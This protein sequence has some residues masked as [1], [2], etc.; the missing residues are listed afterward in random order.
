MEDHL[1]ILNEINREISYITEQDSYI[2]YLSAE[3]LIKLHDKITYLLGELNSQALSLQENPNLSEVQKAQI[4]ADIKKTDVSASRA[5][6]I[7]SWWMDNQPRKNARDQTKEQVQPPDAQASPKVNVPNKTSFDAQASK[8]QALPSTSKDNNPPIEPTIEQ[9]EVLMNPEMRAIIQQLRAEYLKLAAQNNA[10]KWNGSE[11]E[12]MLGEKLEPNLSHAREENE[13]FKMAMDGDDP[14]PNKEGNK[15][16]LQLKFDKVQLNTFSG[17]LTE[18]IAFRDQYLE[19]V[20]LNGNLPEMSK[21]LQLR[22]LLKGI[23][24]DAISSFSVSAADYQAAWSTLMHRYDNKDMIISEYIR[25]FVE[26]PKLSGQPISAKYINMINRTNQLTK[27]LPKLGASTTS[28]DPIL[29]YHLREKLDQPTLKKWRDQVKRRQGVTLSEFKEFL[30]VEATEC[31]SSP[32][33]DYSQL[34]KKQPHVKQFQFKKRPTVLHTAVG[35]NDCVQCKGNH[36]LYACPT[37]SKL[38]IQERIQRAQKAKVCQKC[39][40]KHDGECKLGPCKTCSKNHNHL[41]CYKRDKER[42]Q[43]N[44][45]QTQ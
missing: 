1:K 34:T 42:S 14:K 6:E 8:S 41:L 15:P 36:Q 27:I 18:W 21:Y 7:I 44:D 2:E 35:S 22:T 5:I 26:M 10:F 39:L 29:L 19:L 9:S 43:E 20:H 16:I 37:F 38:K 13:E 33:S 31:A 23:A 17:D 32:R 24:L 30:E 40:T 3:E 45:Q 28:W 12:P 4:Q 11:A 25:K